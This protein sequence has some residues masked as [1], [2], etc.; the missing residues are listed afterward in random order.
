MLLWIKQRLICFKLESSGIENESSYT[1]KIPSER[2][3]NYA[4]MFGTK[5][6]ATSWLVSQVWANYK[7]EVPLCQAPAKM[8]KHHARTNSS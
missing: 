7:D 1:S 4:C 5:V 6:L 2:D 3:S 8:L